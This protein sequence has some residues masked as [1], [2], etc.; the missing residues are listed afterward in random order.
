MQWPNLKIGRIC[1]V[2]RCL[3][4]IG[5]EAHPLSLPARAIAFQPELTLCPLSTHCGLLPARADS[6]LYILMPATG[7]VCI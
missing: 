2:D 5:T 4:S 7:P 6:R 3:P 1:E